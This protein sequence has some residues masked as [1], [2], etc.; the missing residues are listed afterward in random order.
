MPHLSPTLLP[1]KEDTY[2]SVC[3]S[4]CEAKWWSLWSGSRVTRASQ[5]TSNRADAGMVCLLPL[6]FLLGLPTRRCPVYLGLPCPS[7]PLLSLLPISGNP[8]SLSW[9]PQATDLV[10]VLVHYCCLSYHPKIR[11]LKQHPFSAHS[12]Q[13]SGVLAQYGWSLCSESHTANI[14]VS[15]RLPSLLRLRVLL[16]AFLAVSRFQFIAV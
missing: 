4:P 5:D 8:I 9:R 1:G 7:F 6:P 2:G 16:Q 13:G 11:N 10:N 15:A 12:L 3:V 14:R